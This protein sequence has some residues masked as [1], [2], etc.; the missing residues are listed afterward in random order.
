MEVFD[1]VCTLFH[2]LLGFEGFMGGGDVPG[3]AC[4]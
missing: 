2:V 3:R 1:L 4:C